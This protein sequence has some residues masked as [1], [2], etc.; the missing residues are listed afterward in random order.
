M[1]RNIVED[2]HLRDY[3][4]VIYKRRW[5]IIVFFAVLVTVVTILSFTLTPIYSATAEIIIEK[6][7]PNILDIKELYAI[8]TTAQDFY[9]TQYKI[10]ESRF[11]AKM[12]ID[13]LGLKENHKFNPWAGSDSKGIIDTLAFW[14]RDDKDSNEELQLV[15]RFIK[16]LSVEPVRNTRIARIHFESE[17]P[18]LAAQIADTV[19]E[20]Y[21]EQTIE[22]KIAAVHG[23]TD[24]LSRKIEEQRN[25]LEESELLL[26]QY[27]E[28]YNIISLKEKENIT[29]AKLA[30]LNSDVI[31]AE[32]V[33]IEAE[34][35]YQQAREIAGDPEQ[36]ETIITVVQ[37]P[38]IN[39]LKADEANLLNELSELSKKYGEKHPKIITVKEKLK[40]TRESTNSEIIKIINSLKNEYNVA[41]AKERSL[42]SA[43]EKQKEE[44]QRLSKHAITYGVLLRDVET[45]RQ[46]YEILLTRM[47]EAGISGGIQT[48]NVRVVDKADVPREPVKPRKGLNILLAVIVG[49]FGGTGIAFFIE[50]LD[51]AVKTPDDLKRA[52]GIPYMGPI[53]NFGLQDG[54]TSVAERSLIVHEVPKSIA[55]EAYRGIRT[56]VVFASPDSG[57]KVL[58]VTSAAPSEGKSV[59]AANL[60]VAMAQSG[61]KTVIIDADFRKPRLHRIFN[62]KKEK[63]FSNLIVGAAEVEEVI[64]K[65]DVPDLDVI[66]CGHVPPN[67]AELLGSKNMRK[68]LSALKERYSMIIFDSPP[69]MAVTDAIILST[70]VDDVLLVVWAGKTSRE[71]VRRAVEQL[72]DVRANLIGAVLNNIIVGQESYYYYQYYYSYYGDKES[73]EGRSAE[74]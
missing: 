3:L 5:T 2:I 15:D 34:L 11:I 45:N 1:Q 67:P 68:Y 39:K 21:I 13:K 4:W 29:V 10:L 63:G 23:A 73:Q 26:Q 53:P 70:L 42:E 32:N 66:P 22:S 60:A 14:G 44:S 6:E 19:V 74:P 61:N 43:L 31:R 55:A 49:L 24:Y 64:N 8:D 50:Y 56:A 41:L 16:G 65:T 28:Q 59:T 72:R 36:I 69:I 33:R 7:N 62:I 35:R 58:L 37:N 52:V 54:E 51:N 27:K 48:T 20:A 18:V 38:F 9:Q 17:D 30:E 46:M 12:V 25:K 71:V 40:A 47:K 57:N